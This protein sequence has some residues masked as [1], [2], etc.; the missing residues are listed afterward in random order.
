[1]DNVIDWDK[2]VM[3]RIMRRLNEGLTEEEI[4]QRDAQDAIDWREPGD[5][6]D[7]P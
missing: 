1:M 7:A 5:E 4:K 3:A 6:R 2:A